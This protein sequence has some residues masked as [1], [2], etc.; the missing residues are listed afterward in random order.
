MD[1]FFVRYRNVLVLLAL[2]LAQIIGLAVQ[3]RRTDTGRLSLGSGDGS[4][5]RLI[6]LWANALVSP[7]ERAVQTSKTGVGG[8]WENWIDLRHVRQEN[9]D[10]Q[11]TIDRLRTGAGC[12]A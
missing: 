9:K 3:V 6:R 8:F 7:P 11:Q 2:L 1:S 5:V 12:P 4:G 10:L